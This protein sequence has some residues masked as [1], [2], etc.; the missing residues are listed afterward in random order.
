[1]KP[2]DKTTHPNHI[3]IEWDKESNGDW[4]VNKSALKEL[5]KK[6]FELEFRCI[7]TSFFHQFIHPANPQGFYKVEKGFGGRKYTT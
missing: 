2:R 4:L 1:L 3:I 5:V 6:H 7:L